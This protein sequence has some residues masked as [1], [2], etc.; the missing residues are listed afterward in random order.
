MAPPLTAEAVAGSAFSGGGLRFASAA[1]G[2]GLALG[3]TSTIFNPL[4]AALVTAP[5][6]DVLV[7][8]RFTS[9]EVV[10]GVIFVV[11]DFVR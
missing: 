7:A 5:G 11:D 3:G 9:L 2:S 4:E 6:A 8:L 10:G 1:L